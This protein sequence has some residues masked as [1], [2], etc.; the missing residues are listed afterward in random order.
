MGPGLIFSRPFPL[1]SG[2]LFANPRFLRHRGCD[3]RS[4]PEQG[5]RPA[6]PGQPTTSSLVIL[7]FI[8]NLS[9]L[10]VDGTD[11]HFAKLGRP[12]AKH[13]HASCILPVWAPSNCVATALS[14]PRGTRGNA[15][16]RPTPFLDALPIVLLSPEAAHQPPPFPAGAVAVDGPDL[17]PHRKSDG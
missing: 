16:R 14:V 5:Q 2:N 7:Y 9:F 10:F 6:C 17:G 12:H 3:A 11:P 1:S 15:Y 8:P 4:L 13:P